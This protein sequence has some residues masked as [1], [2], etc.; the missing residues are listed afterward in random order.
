[1][2]RTIES[3]EPAAFADELV[4]RALVSLPDGLLEKLAQLIAWEQFR[5]PLLRAWPWAQSNAN[6]GRPSWGRA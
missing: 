5:V 2:S 3:Q 1:M 4:S 6:R